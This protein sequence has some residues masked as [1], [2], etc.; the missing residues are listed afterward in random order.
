MTL[1]YVEF[2]ICTEH[3]WKR[4]EWRRLGK[5]DRADLLAFY[6]MRGTVRRYSAHES[7][8][9]ASDIT[10]NEWLGLDEKAR[11]MKLEFAMKAAQARAK[12]GR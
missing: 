8:L 6:N 4:D 5:K 2:E 11:K 10:L 1:R 3:G 9:E 12:I 7:A